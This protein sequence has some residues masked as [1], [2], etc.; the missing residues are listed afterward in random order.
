MRLSIFLFHLSDMLGEKR[1]NYT[2]IMQDIDS[3]LS[4]GGNSL[5]N[6][7]V[8]EW[9][10]SMLEMLPQTSQLFQNMKVLIERAIEGREYP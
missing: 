7:S 5:A 1:A 10:D 4:T 8:K 6:I 9:K 2:Q 3:E